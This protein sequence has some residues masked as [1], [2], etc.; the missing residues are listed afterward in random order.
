MKKIALTLDLFAERLTQLLPRLSRSVCQ[1]DLNL[2]TQGDITL[3]QLGIL[4][5]LVE[6]PA[7]TMCELA[8]R[9]RLQGATATGM[10]DRLARCGLV[11]RRRS[12]TDRR[13]VHVALTAKGRRCM[14]AIRRQKK[15]TLMHG[16]SRHTT[17]ERARFLDAVEKLERRLSENAGC[18]VRKRKKSTP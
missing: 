7:C 17:A 5:D 15:S 12:T 18:A 2:F 3:P 4:E 6:F 14:E 10:V 11:S 1:Y 16:F 8:A 9:L 13:V